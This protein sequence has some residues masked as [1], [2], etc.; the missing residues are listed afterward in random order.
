MLILCG[1]N[2]SNVACKQQQSWPGRLEELVQRGG[3]RNEQTSKMQA[4]SVTQGA[5][6]Q[7]A[8]NG[9]NA[10]LVVRAGSLLTVH[11]LPPYVP[12]PP[13]PSAVRC[14]L[15]QGLTP[16]PVA[17]RIQTAGTHAQAGFVQAAAQYNNGVVLQ[18]GC[19]WLC[20]SAFSCASCRWRPLRSTAALPMGQGFVKSSVKPTAA[21][22]AASCCPHGCRATARLPGACASSMLAA[23]AC[24]RL[25]GWAASA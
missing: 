9:F 19:P 3:G 13:N 24:R 8:F 1:G 15:R 22:A 20:G 6:E 14:H 16:P 4:K 10:A 2:P 12:F 7:H 25:S 11:M 17:N 21:S 5:M 18:I 23:T